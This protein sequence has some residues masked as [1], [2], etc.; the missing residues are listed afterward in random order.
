MINK[1]GD[2][3]I[4]NLQVNF[5]FNFLLMSIAHN[6]SVKNINHLFKHFNDSA[7]E[8]DDSDVEIY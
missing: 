3:E 2:V 4:F 6:I 7:G 1:N 5:E 8:N